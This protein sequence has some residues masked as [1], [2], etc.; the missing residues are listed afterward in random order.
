V[1]A[2][3]HLYGAI[4][5][6]AGTVYLTA[7][8]IIESTGYD[9]I[10]TNGGTY[11]ITTPLIKARDNC[12][13][14]SGATF[15]MNVDKMLAVSEVVNG[16]TRGYWRV[17]ELRSLTA[18]QTVLSTGGG[19]VIDFDLIITENS[20]AVSANG[21]FTLKGGTIQTLGDAS[22]AIYLDGEGMILRDVK[23]IA[24]SA[25]TYS[26][27]GM[28]QP[29]EM[30]GNI[31]V[32]KPIDIVNA[33]ILGDGMY[34]D[35]STDITYMEKLTA[36]EDS[37][38]TNMGVSGNLFANSLNIS[39]ATIGTDSNFTNM[40]ISG[41]AFL[42]KA[43][44]A[45]DLNV[46][47]N[48]DFN[49]VCIGADCTQEAKLV[50]GTTSTSESYPG[51][52]EIVSDSS[53]API[54]TNLSSGLTVHADFN[55]TPTSGF[56]EAGTFLNTTSGDYHTSSKNFVA[57][58]GG[59]NTALSVIDGTISTRNFTVQ[60]LQFTAYNNADMAKDSGVT[61]STINIYGAN[62]ASYFGYSGK[63][64]SGEKI[65]ENAYGSSIASSI[66]G[67]YNT[68]Q[69]GNNYGAYI[70]TSDSLDN[71]STGTVNNYSL[72]LSTPATSTKTS[73]GQVISYG[74]YG[75]SDVNNVI[76]GKLRIGSTNAPTSALDVSGSVI[77]T[78]DLN[79]TGNVGISGVTFANNDLNVTD[80]INAGGTVKGAKFKSWDANAANGAQ[81]VALGYK[82]TA[83]GNQST[84]LGYQTTASGR[85]ST[86]MGISTNATAAQSIATG[87]YTT[88]S[89]TDSIAMGYNT[90]AGGNGSM[91]AGY[92]DGGTM[93]ATGLGSMTTG[94][95]AS[96]DLS[97]VTRASGDGSLATGYNLD[98]TMT[99]SGN[100]STTG[101]YADY[102]GTITASGKASEARGYSMEGAIT[103]SA[104][105]SMA[106]GYAEG[107]GTIEAIADAGKAAGYC[108][109]GVIR[110]GGSGSAAWGYSAEGTTAA[111]G[112]GSTA[113]GYN[114]LGAIT[115][116]GGGS[117]AGGYV[118][119]GG[120][121]TASGTGS[122]AYGYSGGTL[123]ATQNGAIALGYNTQ[124]LAE[125]A[126]TLGKNL[127]NYNANSVL[128]QDLNALDSVYAVN[129]VDLTP[130]WTGS[131]QDALEQL[132]RVRTNEKGNI[133]HSTLPEFVQAKLPNQVS[134]T[135]GMGSM[136]KSLAVEAGQQDSGTGRN[137]G[138][139]MT[140]LTE[141]VKALKK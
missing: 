87:E 7:T 3:Y 57:L 6:T 59:A 43:T 102:S 65:K 38:F 69:A 19:G 112:T 64:I 68:T 129:F 71:A 29:F 58:Y 20:N 37:N 25:A 117:M 115:A 121:I 72:Y 51:L 26:I 50:V 40:G 80:D 46:L 60:G 39:G 9:A 54:P 105:G 36:T 120:A 28:E 73:G 137:L 124:S 81:A 140:M 96:S 95:A 82:T 104:I 45:S 24:G 83:H 99:A 111:T 5:G 125:A 134:E 62:I 11:Y 116:S 76:N 136:Q 31:Q 55:A 100:G 53:S 13:E 30:Y 66:S 110:A 12:V 109:A 22:A 44:V 132:L 33:P 135:T 118:S 18:S 17:K 70:S 8:E 103:A 85:A 133:D 113:I 32:N 61:T 41:D 52:V 74:L 75:A 138:A 123:Q 79:V 63:T 139:M 47:R 131:S 114:E 92:N 90:T 91:A 34:Y 119:E 2:N 27:T 130:G 107:G 1:S 48:G 89:G 122:M 23:I 141:A 56:N 16:E 42:S 14:S 98:G 88:A 128:V 127:T 101:G 126:V 106:D 94:V 67:T 84:A 77:I 35:S 86:A 108:N 93:E 21:T 78:G 15:Y 49:K 4:G 97:P 10:L